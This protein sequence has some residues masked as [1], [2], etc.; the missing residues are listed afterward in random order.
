[1][2]YPVENPGRETGNRTNVRKSYVYYVSFKSPECVL[3]ELSV[4]CV[5]Y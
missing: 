5:S 4:D 2:L 3:W 1:M